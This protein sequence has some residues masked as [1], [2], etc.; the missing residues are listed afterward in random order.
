MAAQ[1]G[2]KGFQKKSERGKE[3]FRETLNLGLTDL[4]IFLCQP[5]LFC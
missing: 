3:V 5:V 1:I 4:Q 2:K